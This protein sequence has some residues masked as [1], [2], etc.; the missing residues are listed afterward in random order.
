M[1]K[2]KNLKIYRHDNTLEN[3]KRG[4]INILLHCNCVYRQSHPLNSRDY[5]IPQRTLCHSSLE[6]HLSHI[7]GKMRVYVLLPVDLGT[8]LA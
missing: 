5:P 6:V 3:W 8:V 1:L 7:T 2:A 4:E